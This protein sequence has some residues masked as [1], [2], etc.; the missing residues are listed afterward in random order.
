[1]GMRGTCS[2]G[3][4][5]SAEGE[6]DQVL[7]V[8]YPRIHAQSMMPIA[9]LTWSAVWSG[10]AAGAVERARSFLRTASRRSGGQLP[11]G[12]A[13]LTRAT[14]SLA[15]LR[16]MVAAHLRRFEQV[17]ESGERLEALEFQSSMNLLKVN[18]S[19]LAM[20]TVM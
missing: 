6:P 15:A 11:P 4:M 12:A 3:F 20:A 9:H 1:M 7:G 10:I 14:S 2:A 18:A 13:Q 19:E 5:L 17:G 8:P 16:S